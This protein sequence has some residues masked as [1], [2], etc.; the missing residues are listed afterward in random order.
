[1]HYESNGDIGKINWH[2]NP[3]D[4]V[5]GASGKTSLWKL[6]FPPF[7]SGRKS[8]LNPH[9]PHNVAAKNLR[10]SQEIIDFF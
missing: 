9:H 10:R 1:M 8:V 2:P 6:I 3:N 7:S 5:T 4:N